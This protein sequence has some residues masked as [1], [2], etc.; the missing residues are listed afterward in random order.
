MQVSEA[1]AL[2]PG[3]R[4][5]KWWDS[6]A[7]GAQQ[8]SMRVVRVNRTTVTVDYSGGRGRVP[9]NEI[10]GREGEECRRC[11]KVVPWGVL[12]SALLCEECDR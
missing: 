1:Q 5:Y 6:G 3:D 8:M 4:I 2:K 12:N 9:F 10:D 7:M 11:Q